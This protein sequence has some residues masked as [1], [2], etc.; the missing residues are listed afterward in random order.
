MSKLDFV[1]PKQKRQIF[2]WFEAAF[3]VTYLLVASVCGIYMLFNASEPFKWLAGVM[4][5]VLATGDAFHLI[6]RIA[7]VITGRN[8]KEVLGYGKLITSVTM[9]AFYVILWHIGL[10]LFLP[11]LSWLFTAVVYLLA[12]SRITLCLLPQNA[13]CDRKDSANWAVYRNI[14]LVLLG[15]IV[16]VLFAIYMKTVP[17]LQWLWLAVLLSFVFYLPIVL[18]SHKKRIL[19]ML[20]LPKS[21]MYLWILIMFVSI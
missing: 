1:A 17:A 5:I 16:A 19:Y 11:R 20:M 13:W 2:D 14:P 15:L 7:A 6:P 10:L 21:L 9:T 18:W 3:E 4:A 12:V 8:P